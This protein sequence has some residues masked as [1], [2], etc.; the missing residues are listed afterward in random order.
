M[1]FRFGVVGSVGS[2][3]VP[4]W[5]RRQETIAL[6]SFEDL[7]S[8]EHFLATGQFLKLAHEPLGTDL[9]FP[10]SALAAVAGAAV[11]RRA[12]LLGEHNAEIYGEL[13]LKDS[14][15]SRLAAERVI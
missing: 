4:Y 6:S 13:G 1:G 5:E 11:R 10:R 3:V 8:C 2:D 7:A 12:P 14:D 9:S 15:L